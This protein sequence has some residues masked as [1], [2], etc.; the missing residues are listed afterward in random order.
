MREGEALPS[1]G[2]PA[3]D[4]LVKLES[5]ARDA[6]REVAVLERRGAGRDHP[7][8]LGVVVPGLRMKGEG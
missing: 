8:L 2:V 7:V 1:V 4:V 6:H 3:G 5:A